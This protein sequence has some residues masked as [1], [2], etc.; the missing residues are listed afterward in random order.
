MNVSLNEQVEKFVTSG[1]FKSSSEVIREG[2]CLLEE[3]KLKLFV[4]RQEIEAGRKS[5]K[6][7]AFEANA[8][9]RRRRKTP[10]T[11]ESN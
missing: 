11:G 4:L 1:R 10:T 7:I 3:R 5:R 8:I 6:P 9:K 2:L